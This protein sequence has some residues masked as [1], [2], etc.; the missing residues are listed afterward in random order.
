MKLAST[1]SQL[2]G[3]HYFF[4]LTLNLSKTPGV[5]QLYQAILKKY[6]DQPEKKQ[7]L[8]ENLMSVFA[9]SWYR[10]VKHLF[11]FYIAKN[12]VFGD[13]RH[14]WYHF[15]F[16]SED[17]WG[18]LPHVHGGLRLHEGD[19]LKERMERIS[20]ILEMF[21]NGCGPDDMVGYGKEYENLYDYYETRELIRSCMTHNC[22]NAGSRC[23]KL[24]P[25][26]ANPVCRVPFQPSSFNWQIT[27]KKD[28]YEEDHLD[29]LVKLGLAQVDGTN[30][31]LDDRL[32]GKIFNY[33]HHGRHKGIPTIG[34][35]AYIFR[36]STN[37]QACDDK[38]CISYV[39]KYAAGKEEDVDVVLRLD[40]DEEKN[41]SAEVYAAYNSKITS[42]SIA[43]KN[44]R[45][46]LNK[47]EP[48]FTGVALTNIV[49]YTLGLPFTRTNVSYV[50][51][52]TDPYDIRTASRANQKVYAHLLEGENIRSITAR[53]NFEPW[54][55]FTLHQRQTIENVINSPYLCD[56]VT[57]FGI[58][59]PEFITINT[60]RKYFQWFEVGSGSKS[61]RHL[62]EHVDSSVFTD[63]LGHQ[64]RIRERYLDSVLDHFR[65]LL[66]EDPDTIYSEMHQLCQILVDQKEAENRNAFYNSLVSCQDEQE[67]VV[68]FNY[69]KPIDKD[70]FLL[71]HV[72]RFGSFICE[73][74]LFQSANLKE[75]YERAGLIPDRNNVTETDFYN[76]LRQY[77]ME[78][79]RFQP[80]STKKSRFFLLNAKEA[81]EDLLFD[82]GTMPLV[83]YCID[84]MLAAA[85]DDQ[86]QEFEKNL[87]LDAMMKIRLELAIPEEVDN[88]IPSVQRIVG[89]TEQ[90]FQEKSRALRI[91]MDTLQ[92]LTEPLTMLI[93]SPILVG[94]PGSG[95]TYLLLQS[96]AFAVSLGLR[97][98]LM[99][100]TAQR[101]TQIGG[102][103]LHRVFKLPVKFRVG[104]TPNEMVT[105][106]LERLH[107][108]ANKLWLCYLNRVQVFF[109]DEVGLLSWEQLA[110]IDRVL[111]IVR[112]VNTPFGGALFFA[113]GDHYQ[114]LP[115]Q[116]TPLWTSPLLYSSFAVI[117]LKELV[118][119]QGDQDLQNIIG[120]LRKTKMT[121]LD[122][123]NVI[124]TLQRRCSSVQHL[125]QVPREYLV[126]VGKKEA[127]N[128]VNIVRLADLADHNVESVVAVSHDEQRHVNTDR[129][130]PASEAL[131][132]KLDKEFDEKAS[133][134][135]YKHSVMQLTVNRPNHNPAYH[136]GQSVFITNF[137]RDPSGQL[138]VTGKLL[139]AGERVTYVDLV[140]DSWPT[141]FLRQMT[142][143]EVFY[144]GDYGVWAR[145]RQF[146]LR[147]AFAST[148][149][150]AIGDTI[151]HV[152][153]KISVTEDAFAMWE[154][155][156]L[157]VTISR[158]RTL[159]NLLF[160]GAWSEIE[161]AIRK[162]LNNPNGN[163][164]ALIDE[165]LQQLNVLHSQFSIVRFRSKL[166][167]LQA[168]LPPHDAGY[169]FMSVS[170]VF[171]GIFQLHFEWDI[172]HHFNSMNSGA[173]LDVS[174]AP[175]PFLP[176]FF[177]TGFPGE[178]RSFANFNSRRLFVEALRQA[179]SDCRLHS[180]SCRPFTYEHAMVIAELQVIDCDSPEREELCYVECLATDDNVRRAVVQ[181][182][183]PED[184]PANAS[185]GATDTA[186]LSYPRTQYD[187]P[188]RR[189]NSPNRRFLR[190]QDQQ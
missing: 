56:K 25:G 57:S 26:Q 58:R 14:F 113:S 31:Q 95:K 65:D 119:S 78:D 104:L 39:I 18:N 74:D 124:E 183:Y 72:L 160:V 49:W 138:L 140:P 41:V 6:S 37:V 48:L 28:I 23:Q 50:F 59:P 122:K 51:V 29:I 178:A 66:A 61:L 157:T 2:G 33:P 165:R 148:I 12:D 60:L 127:V 181:Y 35:L 82:R 158:V 22:T 73:K 120:L 136:Q 88:Y 139:P 52:N 84:S 112:D 64:V 17:S 118:R 105:G 7:A 63:G 5:A 68:V 133:I 128:K 34:K 107:S 86:L 77:L 152:A 184:G 16:Q 30:I 70:R 135:I 143:R 146:T 169:V 163:I 32:T 91:C 97:T 101:S 121:N 75:S 167:P 115:I 47:V 168:S 156:Q 79:L 94:A 46:K 114:L 21:D 154:K 10:T 83:P 62:S 69:N 24:R 153:L 92:N 45:N 185:T 116:G 180:P 141:L 137:E 123:N 54:R 106:S 85:V 125:Q 147:Y 103:H 150:R 189:L 108:P 171:P 126:L 164:L 172:R 179:I 145:R 93:R 96:Y 175:R 43:Q 67:Y 132:K 130:G 187:R 20:C 182:F 4:T 3:W 186:F 159:S 102:V 9:R 190:N 90:C 188:R 13:L 80:I 162:L 40:S 76:V 111:R 100:F 149:H 134:T 155:A 81:F 71:S 15:E 110:V 36:S 8:I 109:F 151:S 55:Q 142:L 170:A 53:A 87:Q 99:S 19:S 166:N 89:M 11:E 144:G 117:I 98:C 1:F 38:F 27:E 131:T 177:I 176:A 42:A 129:Y 174:R 161:T 44:L 173:S